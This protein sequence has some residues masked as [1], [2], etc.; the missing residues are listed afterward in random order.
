MPPMTVYLI[1][2]RY[3]STVVYPLSP[4]SGGLAVVY[5]GGGA[6]IEEFRKLADFFVPLG[7]VPAPANGLAAVHRRRELAEQVGEG[8]A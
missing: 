2:R 4:L 5:L 1:G 7:D 6:S 8:R 3:A